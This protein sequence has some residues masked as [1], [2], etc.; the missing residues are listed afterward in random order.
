M[1]PVAGTEAGGGCASP[2]RR[3]GRADRAGTGDA[4]VSAVGIGPIGRIGRI[5]LI[6]C[7]IGPIRPVRPIR[8]CDSWDKCYKWDLFI[9]DRHPLQS[10]ADSLALRMRHVDFQPDSLS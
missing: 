4:G 9:P 3:A 5:G 6:R 10:P 7:L 8:P 1:G 2:D